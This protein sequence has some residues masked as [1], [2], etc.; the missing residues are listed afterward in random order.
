MYLQFLSDIESARSKSPFVHYFR[1]KG[2][3]LGGGPGRPA[4]SIV[5]TMRSISSTI[6]LPIRSNG[7][8]YAEEAL[9]ISF[10][11]LLAPSLGAQQQL[12]HLFHSRASTAI[13]TVLA[14][15]DRNAYV[16]P[17]AETDSITAWKGNGNVVI[18]TAAN[19]LEAGDVVNIRKMT[20][21]A[22]LLAAA[23]EGG[24]CDR[25]DFHRQR[26]HDGGGTETTGGSSK[27]SRGPYPDGRWHVGDHYDGRTRPSG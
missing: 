14:G 22:E 18:F 7:K 17:I 26:W 5:Q 12:R 6:V 9:V 25:I 15:S 19:H 13:P 10:A 3:G 2:L 4:N 23:M 16:T 27:R 11:C 24:N 21:A 8:S 20:S 1:V